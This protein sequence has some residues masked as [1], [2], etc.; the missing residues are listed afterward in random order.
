[1]AIVENAVKK[2]LQQ[3]KIAAS[4]N[5]SRLRTVEIPQIAKATGFHWIFIDLEHSTMDMDMAGQVSAV[6]LPTGVTPIVRVPEGDVNRATRV[7]DAGAQG[8][9]GAAQRAG[10]DG[11]GFAASEQ[12]RAVRT[13]QQADLA[14]DWPDFGLRAAIQS[15]LGR[16]H[17]FAHL[18]PDG[19]FEC[20]LGGGVLLVFERQEPTRFG[21]GNRSAPVGLHLDGQRFLQGSSRRIRNVR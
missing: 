2:R 9:V 11:L 1:M 13:R 3:G 10:D 5:V 6:A 16:E 14:P 20:L 18:F 7:L 8:I 4:F 19:V 12:R 15:A 21:R 17:V